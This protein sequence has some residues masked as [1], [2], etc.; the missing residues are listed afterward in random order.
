MIIDRCLEAYGG[1]EFWKNLKRID[2][3]VSVSGLAFS[4]KRRPFFKNAKIEMEVQRP[5]SKITPIGKNEKITGVLEGHNVRLED[6]NGQVLK[7]RKN[8]RDYFPLGRRLFKW[9]D[10]DMAYFANYA[11]WN[12]FTFPNLLLNETIQW[13]EIASGYLL[14][15][16]PDSIPTHSKKQE[17]RF[18]P[19]TGLLKQHNYTANVISKFA[20][21][22]NVVHAHRKFEGIPFPVSRIVTPQGKKGKAMKKPVLINIQ[23]NDI[24]FIK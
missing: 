19:E 2:A 5:Y 11:F 23:V 12:Y 1:A 14:A 22:A 9:D 18:D 6:E 13:K 4:L 15:Q 20:N 8:P 21:A 7:E 24:T 10:L 17:F 3:E 16:F